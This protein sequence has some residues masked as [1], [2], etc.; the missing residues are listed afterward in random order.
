[1]GAVALAGVS[2][3][4]FASAKSAHD[5]AQVAASQHPVCPAAGCADLD[6]DISS[7]RSRATAAYVLAGGAGLAAVGAALSWTLLGPKNEG[8]KSALQ[9]TP[10]L[11]PT[12]GGFLLRGTF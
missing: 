4:L 12:H 2:V 11:S 8:G 5:D 10:T 1:V 9:I 7:E 6:S 3:A